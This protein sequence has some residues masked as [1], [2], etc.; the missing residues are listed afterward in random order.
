MVAVIAVLLPFPLTFMRPGSIDRVTRWSNQVRTQSIQY[1]KVNIVVNLCRIN[2]QS[3]NLIRFNGDLLNSFVSQLSG[4]V[5]NREGNW[6]P[7]DSTWRRLH[8]I[9]SKHIA[10]PVTIS[11]SGATCATLLT[12]LVGLPRCFAFSFVI[13]ALMVGRLLDVLS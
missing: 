13:F 2:S 10:Y 8:P 9:P 1:I 4:R 6:S 5:N 12:S 11:R 3:G 7:R